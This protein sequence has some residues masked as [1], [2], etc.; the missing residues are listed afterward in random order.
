MYAPSHILTDKGCNF[1]SLVLKELMDAS[2]IHIHQATVKHDQTI[3]M[4]EDSHQL[5]KQVLKIN[6]DC[7]SPQCD[8][9]VN[10]AVMAHSTMYQQAIK[11]SPTEI[12]LRRVP[13]IAPDLKFTNPIQAPRAKTILRQSFTKSKRSTS[14]PM[15]IS[16]RFSTNASVQWPQSPS[17]TS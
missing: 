2:G 13:Y 15:K 6:V 1:S 8:S 3:G 10:L 5:L 12:L 16:L 11:C 4:I 9:Y 17:R 14:V 7:D